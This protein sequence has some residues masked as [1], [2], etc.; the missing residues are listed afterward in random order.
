MLV[1]VAREAA[2]ARDG[3]VMLAATWDARD[4]PGAA[5]LTD[6]SRRP[7]GYTERPSS[8]KKIIS[9]WRQWSLQ[10]NEWKHGL[11]EHHM[12]RENNSICGGPNSGN[13]YVPRDS[14]EKRTWQSE[15]QV[16]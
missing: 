9:S 10:V 12:A 2:G 14:Q 7:M 8:A 5:S 4:P 11:I 6:G 13:L 15:A 3:Q 1:G 16:C